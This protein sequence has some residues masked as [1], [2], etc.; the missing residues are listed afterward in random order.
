MPLYNRLFPWARL[1][2]KRSSPTTWK[3][4][5]PALALLFPMESIFE[6]YVAHLVR[7]VAPDWKVRTQESKRS[8]ID[9]NHKGNPEFRLRPDIVAR[10]GAEIRIMDVKWK[11]LD[12]ARAHYN[13]SQADLYQLY[14]YGKKYERETLGDTAPNPGLYLLYPWNSQFADPV[15]FKYE[16]GL[17]LTVFPVNLALEE[18]FAGESARGELLRS[19]FE[20]N[21][22]RTNHDKAA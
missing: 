7:M 19:L 16:E 15:E 13:I 9:K 2:L 3:D 21:A 10:R 11:R 6:D 22:S 20:P 5:N 14:A 17:R 18:G 8:L 1:F 4:N 12:S